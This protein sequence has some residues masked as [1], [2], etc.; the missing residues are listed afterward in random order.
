ELHRGEQNALVTTDVG[1][2]GEGVHRL[3][4]GGPRNR[5]GREGGDLSRRERTY[6]VEVAERHERAEID[7]AGAHRANLV[8][9]GLTGA[10]R[11]DLEHKIGGAEKGR[12]IGLRLDADLAVGGVRKARGLA[13]A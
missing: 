10:R 4:P 5:V 6:G 12:W 7:R 9:S 13:G 11:R 3:R 1:H 8:P 2:R